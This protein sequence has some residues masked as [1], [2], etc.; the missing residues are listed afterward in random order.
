MTTLMVTCGGGY[1]E[2][3]RK[4]IRGGASMDLQDKVRNMPWLLLHEVEKQLLFPGILMHM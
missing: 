1:I 4:L 3:V 2:V